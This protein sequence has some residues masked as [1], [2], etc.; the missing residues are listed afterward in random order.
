M[1]LIASS[2]SM[3][4]RKLTALSQM[5][6]AHTAALAA[7]AARPD[8]CAVEV[9][10]PRVSSCLLGVCMLTVRALETPSTFIALGTPAGPRATRPATCRL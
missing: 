1:T 6:L 3:F 7:L 2:S 5:N 4:Q 9:R 10:R 8:A